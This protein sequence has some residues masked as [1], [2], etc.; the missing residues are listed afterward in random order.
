MTD[1]QQAPYFDT[2]AGSKNH[3]HVLFAAGRPVQ[4]R[5]L[6]EAQS[7]VQDQ[8]GKFADHVFKNGSRV[9]NGS[10]AIVEHEY[11]RLKD[12]DAD[13]NTTK[14][15]FFKQGIELEGDTSGV[16]AKLH[17]WT[18]KEESDPVTLFVLYTATGIDGQQHR[19]LNGETLKV[20]DANLNTV[21]K[22]VV[23]C[24]SCPQSADDV[25]EIDPCAFGAKFFNVADGVYY[26]NGF[27]VSVAASQLVFSKYGAPVTCKIGFDVIERIV[28]AEEDPTLYD[29]ALGYPNEASRGADRIVVN[30]NLVKR[31][32][33]VAD[34]TQFVELAVIED[35][36]VQLLKSDFQYAD[37][38]D[39]L[40]KRTY[41]ESGNYTVVPFEVRYREHKKSGVNDHVGFKLD[42]DESLLQAVIGSGI[43]YV[44]GY[45]TET[46]YDSTVNV[47]KARTTNKIQNGSIYFAERAYM[48]LVP[49]DG[50]SVWP[51]NP[52]S[53]SIVSMKEVQFYD[54]EPNSDAP[55][56]AV[57]GSAIVTDA[58]YI[59]ENAQ[60]KPIWRYYLTALSMNAGANPV[61]CVSNET[62]RFLAVPNGEFTVNNQS[63]QN[64][65]FDTSNLNVKSL[66]DSDNNTRGSI[67]I[68]LRVKLK[69][70]LDAQGKYT[71]TTH[72]GVF[73]SNIRDT[74]LIVGSAGNYQSIKA[75][76]NTVAPAGTT[77]SVDVGGTHAGKDIYVIHNLQ[78]LDV[79]EKTK[80]SATHII[81][82]IKRTD[83]NNFHD[84]IKVQRADAY[85]IEYVHSYN[86][87]TPAQ[88]DDITANFDLYNGVTHYAYKESAIKQKAGKQVN[89]NHDMIEVKIRYFNHSDTNSAG[90][91]TIDSYKQVLDDEES[92]ITYANLPVAV[93]YTGKVYSVDRILDFRP[94]IMDLDNVDAAIPAT[95]ETAV[96]DV[97][98]YVGR[99]DYLCVD[100]DGHFFHEYGT[101]SDNPTPPTNL[102]DD[103]MPLYEVSIPAYT[104]SY[105][106]VKVKRIENKRYTMRDIGR[107]ETRI[108]N[109]EYYTS[110]SMLESEA[111]GANVK[112]SNGL[113]RYKNGFMVD[114]F[115]KHSTGETASHEYRCTI[116]KN[117]K[118][119]RPT[120]TM[121]SRKAEFKPNESQNA[122]VNAGI[123][124]LPFKK[125]LGDEQPFGTRPLS[126]N[127][128]LIYR[129]AGQ[130]V[131]TPNVD[132]WA[133]VE[134]KP[135]MVANIDTGVDALKQI[136]NRQNNIVSAFNDWVFANSTMQ[137]NGTVNS[138][139]GTLQSQVTGQSTRTTTTR[140]TS[141]GSRLSSFGSSTTETT[142]TTTTTTTNSIDTRTETRGSIESRTNTYRY[143]AVTDV[144][145]MPYMRATQI[146]FT[147]A[148]LAPN[149]RFYVF[150]DNQNVTGMTTAT[151]N[152][153]DVQHAVTN[154]LL[155]SNANGVLRGIINIPANRF[156]T[157]AKEVRVTND[158]KNTKDEKNE[159]SYAET[160]FFA[161]GL[162]TQRQGLTMNVATATYNEQQVTQT[163]ANTRTNTN[164]TRTSTTRS[165]FNTGGRGGGRDPI[166]QSFKFD[167]DCFI[168][169]ID[170]YFEAL[171]KGDEIWLEIREMDNGYPTE[172]VLSKNVLQT[173]KL[174][175]S[176]DAK[177]AEHVVFPVPVRL[178][179][180]REYCFVIGGESPAT[181]VWVAKLGETAVNV[182]NKV[183]DTQVT[184]GSSF[185]S[186][187]GSTWNAEQ[188]EDIMY[189]LY[190]CEFTSTDMTVRFDISGGA[191]FAP[192]VDAPFETEANSNLVRVY[193]KNP[194]GLVEGD[195]LNLRL[196]PEFEYHVELT[197]GH[198]MVGHELQIN[199]GRAKAVVQSIDYTTPTSAIVKLAMLEGV[200]SNNDPFIANPYLRKAGNK[201][202]LKAYLDLAVED[203]DIKQA[204]GRFT[205]E[206]GALATN[207]IPLEL[208]N[209]QHQVKR[210][211]D[212]R[213]F[214]IE[215]NQQALQTGRFG[216]SGSIALINHKADMLN[217]SGVRLLHDGT[218]EWS[219]EAVSHGEANSLFASDNYSVLPRKTFNL[220]DDRYLDRPIKIASTVNENERMAG[221]AS[222]Q[223]TAKL[224]GSK[225]LSPQVNIDT[226]S[227]VCI[228]NDV[229]WTTADL[230]DR[231]PNGSGRFK[232][233]TNPE[234]GSEHFTYVTKT[235]ILKNPAADLRLWFDA[236]KPA[237]AD[238]DIYVKLKTLGVDN[239]NAAP[240]I[241]VT[242]YDKT[243]TSATID[244]RVE[245]DL[246]LSDLLPAHTGAQHLFSEFKV[247]LVGRSKN[248]A[249]PPLI[250]NLRIIAYT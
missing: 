75:D 88:F 112:D 172:T 70:S 200:I 59:G 196:Y 124:M 235:A 48:D 199:N 92:G 151:G 180:G 242:G 163:R 42:G 30:F 236:F 160:Q 116:D 6:N 125:V 85:K 192:L 169:A 149:T 78:R 99:R 140:E 105:Q 214:V 7:I 178:Q 10:I 25:N 9:S 13:G 233:E 250:K 217:I 137:G 194:H 166:A 232:P 38:M 173:D 97:E 135:D 239:I 72:N 39:T 187:N 81:T 87:A 19:F 106:D 55:T 63:E 209:K 146:E 37:L 219:F 202:M 147:A 53:K 36:Y 128:Y 16:K 201:D 80:Q 93:S 158:P 57:V 27:F 221:R 141:G 102:T 155:L 188:Y 65:F 11:V 142:T 144:K 170:V 206:I 157:G 162:K 77:L 86:A 195:K 176:L 241:L 17:A 240:W 245:I 150:F 248:S 29:N 21:Y 89:N 223:L 225:Y 171:A 198:L 215:V 211:D 247:K 83:T 5:E 131:L 212:S 204:A 184:L 94:V 190:V 28:T 120:Y 73:D 66:R 49:L 115:S 54:G 18:P 32:N 179:K 62:A 69:A 229:A 46:I 129:K 210:V 126:I 136:V 100:R 234:G 193:T 33:A 79:M 203:Y 228:S 68:T 24:P 175:A 31:N 40:A 148:G 133:D 185:R 41:E 224:K 107:L 156:F 152:S 189:K 34:G 3:K 15:D 14:L 191:E 164:V 8:L 84:L 82:N 218:E 35:G 243:A 165:R 145:M 139:L 183:V 22:V 123:A 60:H 134:R 98:Y 222:I 230:L 56:G 12:L 249:V 23:R 205:N 1:K 108:N 103:I 138:G 118:E 154:N 67:N 117:R 109:L 45:R 52:S 213:T 238:I 121:V 159:T 132:T 101:P 143:D 168:C 237:H 64:L 58:V 153:E 71:F 51:N 90:Y 127:P 186:Q 207:G 227:A 197:N 231:N 76:S 246:L 182:P 61:K 226:F 208:L 174:H 74:I 47:P 130:L 114:D 110:L 220:N 20:K 113:D 177:T 91:F 95:K 44:K 122:V 181:R 216:A 119:L 111:A 96:F 2:H 4:A 167:Y 43:A 244:D 50:L 104:Y 26:Y 161:G